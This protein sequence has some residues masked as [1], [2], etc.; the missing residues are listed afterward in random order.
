M[1][2]VL[3]CVMGGIGTVWGPV[4]GA[5]VMIAINEY[6][7]A[8]FARF[9]GLNLV[10]YGCLVIVIVLFLPNG[11]ISLLRRDFQNKPLKGSIR[12]V[13]DE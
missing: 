8:Y 3:V 2:I 4:L 9:S 7:R 12:I 1:L 10:I 6:S 13:K 11:L 5:F